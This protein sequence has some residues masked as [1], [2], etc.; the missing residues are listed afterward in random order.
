MAPLLDDKPNGEEH[1]VPR[2][3]VIGAGQRGQAYAEAIQELGNAKIVAVAEPIAFQRQSFGSKYIWGDNKT[4]AQGE[5]FDNWQDFVAFE[6]AR[7]A[8]QIHG[9]PPRIDAVF[10]CVLDEQHVEVITALAPFKFHLMCEKPLATTLRD[11]LSIYTALQPE[12]GRPPSFIFGIGHVLRYSP[13]NMLLRDLV[14]EQ[15]VIGDVLS[16]E[17]TEPVGWWHYSHSYVR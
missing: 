4:A 14:L 7:R 15:N 9:S 12:S 16:I 8:G 5:E 3:L 11:C 10:V 6:H 13:H 1:Y 2:I 17:H